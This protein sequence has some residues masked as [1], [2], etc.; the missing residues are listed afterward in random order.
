MTLDLDNLPTDVAL[1]QQIVRDL[2]THILSLRAKIA[3]LRA[4]KYGRSSE[5]RGKDL[6]EVEQRLEETEALLSKVGVALKE[7][8]DSP[9][10]KPLPDHLPRTE[11]VLEP[12]PACPSCG[13]T[14]FR[15]ISDDVSEVLDYVPSSLTVK[16]FIR[17][18]CACVACETIV[19]AYAPSKTIDKGKAG[20][21]LLAH[22]MIQKYQDHLPLYR[23]SQMY[24]REGIDLPRSTL[25]S[26]S[27][28]CAQL[29]TP[30]V[31][32]IKSFVFQGTHI[33]GD[34]TPVKVLEPGLGKTKTG[35]IWTYVRDGRPY[36]DETPPAVCYFYSPDRKG[37]RPR[38]HLKD[39]QGVFHADAYRGYDALY[40]TEKNPDS[41]IVEAACWAHVRRKFVEVTLTTNKATVAS[42]VLESL[43]DLYT[44]EEEIR[45]LPPPE[46]YRHRQERSKPLVET[47]FQTLEKAKSQIPPKSLTGQGMAYALNHRIALERFLEDGRIDI[48][49]NAAERA[50]RPIALGRKNWL[51]AGS[52]TGGETAAALYTLLETLKMNKIN[53]QLYLT[54]VFDRI[55]DYPLSK[56]KDLLPWNLDLS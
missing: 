56:I 14:V 10:R 1:L 8:Q 5:K 53:P 15:K 51:F 26:W 47:L 6:E 42:T 16:R 12:D 20:P 31:D 30:L 7:A 22:V 49:N 29:L 21:G 39:F 38:D 24:E 46:R 44:I 17:P 19:Q 54:K 3:L 32:E 23:Q 2:A 48:D 52:D 28:S 25:S 11:T 18:R 45:G 43:S 13:G 37:E 4:K 55:Q 27:L 9:K 35:R 33:H 40:Q 41:S 50:I 36:G 34:D